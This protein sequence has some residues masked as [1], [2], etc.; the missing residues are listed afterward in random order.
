MHPRAI[1]HHQRRAALLGDVLHRG[2]DCRRELV[3]H[4][5]H[6]VLDG[7]GGAFADLPPVHVDAAHARLG[8]ERHKRRP[9]GL[10]IALAYA[11]L[12]FCQDDDAAALWGL[13]GERGQL[14][15]IRQFPDL[16]P[17]SREER[18]GLTVAEGDRAGLV[19]Q[20][21]VHIARG[22]HGAPGHGDDVGLDHAVHAGDAN[23]RQQPPDGGRN[24]TDQQRHQHGD[25][26]GRALSSSVHAVEGERQQRHRRQQEDDGQRRQQNV[27]RN[28][29]GGLLAF[30]A[31]DHGNHAVEE[32][33]ARIGRDAYD[34]PIRQH[35]RATGHGTAVAAALAN[36]RGALAGDGALVHGGNAFNHL[37]IAGNDI[38]RL[39]DDHVTL[40][41][42]RCR[43]GGKR[44][45][46]LGAGQLLGRDIAPGAAQRVGLG[47]A[48]AFGHG[49]RE[50]GEDHRE[51]QPQGDGEN[52]TGWGFAIADQRLEKQDGGQHAADLDHKHHRI[53]HL[54]PWVEF[55]QCVNR[56]P[57]AQSMGRRANGL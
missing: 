46:I 32:G 9:H 54:M 44:G 5:L 30:G 29:V 36:D 8:R 3:V 6:V 22:L 11:I 33:L 24:E 16:H 20:Q 27:E 17:L 42:R 49:L 12:F 1:D 14:G 23:R 43:D 56:W 7:I 45:T 53:L 21:H 48:A 25:R 50:V 18:R 2:M 40:A 51:P 26:D 15:G 52:K 19:E 13:I 35:P 38:A 10:D 37:P 57:A 4:L 28:L 41:Q 47:L 39:D 31:F 34:Q 55:D